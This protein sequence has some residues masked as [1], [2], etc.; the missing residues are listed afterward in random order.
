MLAVFYVN[1]ELLF[2]DR[3]RLGRGVQLHAV[4]RCFLRPSDV[5]REHLF[6]ILEIIRRAHLPIKVEQVVKLRVAVS[7]PDAPVVVVPRKVRNHELQ[8]GEVVLRQK[9][10]NDPDDCQLGL[11]DVHQSDV[12]RTGFS[13]ASAAGVLSFIAN[14]VTRARASLVLTAAR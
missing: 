5:A 9:V 7:L 12:T 8:V 10:I 14:S 4:E 6:H 3:V 11:D 2:L 13:A 1:M